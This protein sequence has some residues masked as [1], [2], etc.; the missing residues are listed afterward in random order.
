MIIRKRKKE[1]CAFIQKIVTTSWQQT[2]RGIVSDTFLN[3]LPQ[4]EEMRIQNSIHQFDEKDNPYLVLEVDEKI[5]GFV[6]YA[7]AEDERYPAYGEITALYVLKEY[8]GKGYG[9]L[10]F[11]KAISELK[12]LHF[13]KM[14]VGCLKGNK[15]NQF[16]QHMGGVLDSTRIFSLT[17]E[18]LIENVY[19][20]SK[21]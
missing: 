5:V 10:L 6:R 13:D 21:N 12:K 14:I 19:V 20:F 17:G 18:D 16:Y 11:E 15:T 1:D 7:K 2:Y 8:H 4:T 9:K 3:N